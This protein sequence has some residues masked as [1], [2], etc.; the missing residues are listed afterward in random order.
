MRNDF[1]V[2]D[3]FNL[4]EFE[5]PCCQRVI[6]DEEFIEKLEK[7]R[8]DRG[9]IIIS[10][11]GGYRCEAYQKAIHYARNEILGMPL[12]EPEIAAHTMGQAA[13]IRIFSL[14]NGD[15]LP[16]MMSDVPYLKELGFT[17][18]GVS[19][20]G[21]AHLDDAHPTLRTWSYSY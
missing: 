3:H 12:V 19:N 18:I 13:D 11:G 14:D 5:C 7:L 8:V 9:R 2:T 16:I 6:L 10:R 15:L 4:R 21:W 20:F 17:G 1:Q